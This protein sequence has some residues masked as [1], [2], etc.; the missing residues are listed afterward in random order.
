MRRRLTVQ[1]WALLAEAGV[2]LAAGSAAVA[3]LPF[4][5]VA[6]M[7]VG[8]ERRLTTPAVP[9]RI[10]QLR[11]AIEAVA[12]R[13]P[14]RALCFER[15]LA[16]QWMLRRRGV[17]STLFYG[18][19]RAR[20]DGLAA[21]VWVRTAGLDVIGCENAGDYVPVASFPPEGMS[22]PASMR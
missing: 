10:R 18:I 14:F 15:G 2:F 22:S 20:A 17:A 6:R 13:V 12:R 16:A 3:L 11:W 21:H 5:R 7:A 1:Q 9:A 19:D 8:R 4:A